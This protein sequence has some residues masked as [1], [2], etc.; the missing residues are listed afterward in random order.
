MHRSIRCALG[1]ALLAV[2]AIPVVAAAGAEEL[3]PVEDPAQVAAPVAGEVT[4]TTVAPDAAAPD[5]AAP[6]PEEPTPSAPAGATPQDPA[7]T[8]EPG[9]AEDPDAGA[10]APAPEAAADLN[11]Q[12]SC[13]PNYTGA[14]VPLSLGDLDCADIDGGP[15][16][17][18]G[19]DPHGLDRDGDGVACESNGPSTTTPPSTAPPVTAP[20]TTAPPATTPPTAPT[21]AVLAEVTACHSSYQGDCLPVG[22]DLDCGEIGTTDLLVVGPDDYG[23]DSDGDGIGCESSAQAAEVRGVSVSRSTRTQHATTGS[24]LELGLLGAALLLAGVA[25]SGGTVLA[26]HV[27]PWRTRGG[28]TVVRADRYGRERRTHVDHRNG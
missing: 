24:S 7:P 14:C 19:A 2:V 8:T 25:V 23:L 28:F 27:G 17:V 5:V 21:A 15:I 10:A 6:Q 11:A 18:V 1:A 12:Q 22:A 20:P 13:D 3:T 9:I 26:S 4:T 16:Q